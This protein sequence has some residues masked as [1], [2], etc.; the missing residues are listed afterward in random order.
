MRVSIPFV[1]AIHSQ[2]RPTVAKEN[3]RFVNQIFLFQPLFGICH[4]KSINACGLSNFIYC[5]F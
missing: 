1:S 3:Q 5:L 4:L 2:A